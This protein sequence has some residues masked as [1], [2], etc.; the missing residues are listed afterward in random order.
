M[1]LKAAEQMVVI[2]NS[3]KS[4][5]NRNVAVDFIQRQAK[6]AISLHAVRAPLH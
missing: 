5:Q 6:S 2:G 3:S 1:P 4:V